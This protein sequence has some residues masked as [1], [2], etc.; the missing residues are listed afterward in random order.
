VSMGV[1]LEVCIAVYLCAILME[2]FLEGSGYVIATDEQ[3]SRIVRVPKRKFMRGGINRHTLERFA[4][5]A[6]ACDQVGT[7]PEGP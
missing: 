7:V 1:V 5:S 6:S 4:K 3:L 2:L